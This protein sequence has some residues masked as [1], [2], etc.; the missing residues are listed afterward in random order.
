MIDLL[1]T[2]DNHY[3]STILAIKEEPVSYDALTTL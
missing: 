2:N 1:G 3:E